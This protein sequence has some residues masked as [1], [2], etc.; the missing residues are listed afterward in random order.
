MIT[1]VLI[2]TD[3]GFDLFIDKDPMIE[4]PSGRYPWDITKQR[5]SFKNC[6][7]VFV[8]YD[9]DELVEENFKTTSF[10]TTNKWVAHETFRKGFRKALEL[11]GDKKFTEEDMLKAF[12]KGA[13]FGSTKTGNTHYF[14]EMIKKLKSR[15]RV[16]LSTTCDGVQTGLCSDLCDCN[17]I[18]N[19]DKDGCLILERL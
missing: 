6:E 16:K 18:I 8:G 12:E 9:L 4:I 5:L 1:G 19:R 14:D 17:L 13:L 3:D 15:V 11:M 7:N 10:G 2:K